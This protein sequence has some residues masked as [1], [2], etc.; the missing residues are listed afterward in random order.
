MGIVCGLG[1]IK[2]GS[3]YYYTDCCGNFISGFNNTGGDLEVSFNYDLAR[4]GVGKLNVPATTSCP[5]PTPTQL[6]Q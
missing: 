3:E 1:A 6:K 2:Q 5:S 4:G